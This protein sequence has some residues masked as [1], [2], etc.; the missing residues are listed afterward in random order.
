MRIVLAGIIGRYPWGGVTWCSLMYLLGLKKLGHEVYYLEDTCECNYD[1]SID[2]IATDPKYALDYIDRSLSPFEFGD[3]WCYVDYTGKHHGIGEEKWRSICASTD[4]FLVLSGGCWIWRDRYLS[5]PIK[6]FIDSDPGF[7]QLAIHNATEAASEDEK[8]RWYIDYFRTYDRLFTFGRNIGTPACEIPVGDLSWKHTWQPICLDL[9][10]TKG[11]IC[12]PRKD[13]TTV[14]TWEIESFKDIGGNK[15]RE[16]P[17]I[18]ELAERCRRQGGPS[19]ELA[20]NGPLE[21]LRER[22]WRCVEAYPISSDLWRYRS[23][24]RSSRGEFS[25]AKHTYVSNNTG[26]FSDRTACY[27]A[28]GLPAVVQDTGFSKHLPTGRGLYAWATGEEAFEFLKRVEAD[29]SNECRAAAS[30]A[31]DHLD[32]GAV[33]SQV[34]KACE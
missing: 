8:K 28:S 17:K 32:A 3:R 24:I 7:T 27:L 11:E 33:L 26:W 15:N 13:W 5:I 2:A 19:F 10:S 14:M 22:G 21:E 1:P 18:L 9:W 29:Y 12:P 31:R 30:I 6:A 20:I 34:L 4:L 25:V 23:Y 16:F